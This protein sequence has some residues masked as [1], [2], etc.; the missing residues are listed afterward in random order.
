[1][2]DMALTRSDHFEILDFL[3]SGSYGSVYAAKAKGSDALVAIKGCKGILTSRTLAKRTLRE[4]RI[5]RFC[6]HPNIVK[7]L[8]VLVPDDTNQLSEFDFVFELLDTDLS[9]I[10][11]SPQVLMIDHV[12]YFTAQLISAMEYLHQSHV[13]HRDVK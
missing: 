3:G 10:I 5:L 13:I 8:T 4:I 12:Q 9:Q 11:R 2:A 6:H 1:M 7:L